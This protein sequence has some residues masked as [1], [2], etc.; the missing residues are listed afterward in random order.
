MAENIFIPSGLQGIGSELLEEGLQ[1]LRAA[2]LLL[3]DSRSPMVD[4]LRAKFKEAAEAI[5]A[6]LTRRG[7]ELPQSLP[8]SFMPQ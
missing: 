2:L 3:P 7:E 4:V 5:E 1:D 8:P 6:E